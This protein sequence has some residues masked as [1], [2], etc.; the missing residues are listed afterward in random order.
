[1]IGLVLIIWFDFPFLAKTRYRLILSFVVI[2]PRESLF[3]LKPF[4]ARWHLKEFLPSGGGGAIWVGQGQ[5]GRICH[6]LTEYQT[7]CKYYYIFLPGET[8]VLVVKYPPEAHHVRVGIYIRSKF[9][10][11]IT[12][13][14]WALT[15]TMNWIK[16]ANHSIS[17]DNFYL[18]VTIWSS[19]S[20]NEELNDYI[21]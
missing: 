2:W 19:S 15:K 18:F 16:F 3:V 20:A 1:M 17:L 4:W 6:L 8:K 9:L 13:Q 5:G 10:A 12:F 21:T 11:S 7:I 14:W